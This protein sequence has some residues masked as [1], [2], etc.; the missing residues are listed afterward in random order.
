MLGIVSLRL[1]GILSFLYCLCILCMGNVALAQNVDVVSPLVEESEAADTLLPPSKFKR[2]VSKVS[3]LHFLMVPSISVTPETS[4]SFGVAGAY[5]FTAK[6]QN[7]LSD[8]GFDGAYTLNHQWNVNVNSTVFFGG[9]NRW[10]LWTR[11]GYRNFPDYYYGIGNKKDKLL[12]SPVRYDSDNAY[13]TLQPQYYVDRHWSVGGN[14]VMYYDNAHTGIPLSDYGLDHVYG[15]NEQLLMMGFG[16]IA[17]YDSRNEIYYPSGGLFAKAV[18]TYYESLLNPQYRMG[19]LSLDF[20][21][22]LTLYRQ[23]VFAYQFRSEMTFG[24]AVPYQ[25]RA[26]LGG[27]DLVRGVR[28]GMFSD[29]AYLALQAELRFPVWR[30]ISGT[31][32]AGVGD[33]YNFSD[34]IWVMPKIG[35]GVGLRC[36]INKSKVNIRFDVARN[37]VNTSWKKDGWNFYLTVKE[38]F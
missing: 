30:I 17:S 27:M 37:N 26:V 4:W 13:L 31:V 16:F 2:F 14:L 18:L 19:K 34:W 10:Q 15:L 25:M 38:A 22:Y 35:Y 24:R 32:F 29:D 8:I 6:G 1:R 9:N 11:V 33:V 28:R 23:L 5:Y 12:S 7:K 36:A 20:R 21:H 3:D